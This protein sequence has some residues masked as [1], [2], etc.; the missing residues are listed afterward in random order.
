MR[1]V[2]SVLIVEDNEHVGAWLKGC[3]ATA[4]S[5]PAVTAAHDLRSAR[6]AIDRVW[7]RAMAHGRRELFDIALID[8]GLPDGN[9]IDLIG[10]IRARDGECLCV[11]TTIYDDDE[12]LF[13]AIEAGA[14]GYLLKF[15]E[16]EKLIELLKRIHDGEPPL[17][18][19]IARRML[20]ALQ[21]RVQKAAA[22]SSDAGL[23]PREQEVLA[24]LGRG[25]QLAQVA[26]NLA[27]SHNTASSHVKSI[28]RKLNISNR[29]EAA[30]AAAGR[31]L[32][33]KS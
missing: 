25:Y 17:S 28:Y 4:F 26:E 7:N 27:I 9:G 12:H 18:P 23:T 30:L 8:I 29:A 15:H 21:Q 3:V 1:P 13:H 10:P 32:L 20:S 19:A 24:L 5:D 6:Q 33:E 2:R 31:G 11:V 16:M 14:S 22:G